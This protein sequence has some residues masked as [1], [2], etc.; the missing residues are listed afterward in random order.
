[1]AQVLGSCH[2]REEDLDEVLG[3]W[4]QAGTASA[5]AGISGMSQKTEDLSPCL[6]SKLINLFKNFIFPTQYPASQLDLIPT[7]SYLNSSSFISWLSF[8]FR[9]REDV[10]FS[11]GGLSKEYSFSVR[12]M[13]QH[14]KSLQK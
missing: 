6:S 3:S 5:I 11:K 7:L 13:A 1:M 12:P 8:V 10:Q 2:P 9:A 4:L 14:V